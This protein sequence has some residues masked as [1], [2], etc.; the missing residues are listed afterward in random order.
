MFG[1]VMWLYPSEMKKKENLDSRGKNDIYHTGI[2]S[3]KQDFLLL[4]INACTL[5]R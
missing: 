1:K 4:K 3:P 2:Y 5:I